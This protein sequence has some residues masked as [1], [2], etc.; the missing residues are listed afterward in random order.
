MGKILMAGA[1]MLAV[2]WVSVAAAQGPTAPPGAASQGQIINTPLP[3]GA[4]SA[5]TNNN[6]NAFMTAPGSTVAVTG[7]PPRVPEGQAGD[8]TQTKP[9]Q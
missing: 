5:F 7:Q 4:A 6:S 9:G 1:A 3:F 8:R 2:G